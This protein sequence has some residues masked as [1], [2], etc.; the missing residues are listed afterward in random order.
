MN[1]A[2]SAAEPLPLCMAAG[3]R[4][5]LARHATGV[6]LSVRPRRV[7]SHPRAAPIGDD[8]GPLWTGNR[9]SARR[10]RWRCPLGGINR[11]LERARRWE[12]GRPIRQDA[13]DV[14]YAANKLYGQAMPRLTPEDWWATLSEADR[15][16]FM[17]Q[18]AVG[19][20]VSLDLW[21]KMRTTGVLAA[22]NGYGNHPWEY[23]LVGD[24]LRYVLA[25]AAERTGPPRPEPTD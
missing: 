21:M 15:A 2:G 8:N 3:T 18:V 17:D 12:T 11:F 5:C 14:V 19:R 22:P 1:R 25:R 7:R 10:S 4:R 20:R 23:Y 6:M 9:P 16:A 24:H 13:G